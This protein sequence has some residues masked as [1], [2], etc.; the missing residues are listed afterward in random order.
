MFFATF[1]FQVLNKRKKDFLANSQ[2]S[3]SLDDLLQIHST[4]LSVVCILEYLQHLKLTYSKEIFG[5]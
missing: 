4:F 2:Y 1:L 5:L 3:Q